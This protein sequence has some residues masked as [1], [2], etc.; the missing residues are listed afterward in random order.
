VQVSDASIMAG[1]SVIAV[2]FVSPMLFPLNSVCMEESYLYF[3]ALQDISVIH[4]REDHALPLW[5]FH[6]G[7]GYP[8]I[9]HSESMS[10]SP[11]FYLFMLPFGT[12]VGILPVAS[13]GSG[14]PHL[15]NA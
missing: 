15:R 7:G 3:A 8:L 1:L 14:A 10:L 11:L 2:L 5:A 12:A 4:L 13:F 6:F 9:K